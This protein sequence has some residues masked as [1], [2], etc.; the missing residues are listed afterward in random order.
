MADSPVWVQFKIIGMRLPAAA[1]SAA[2]IA[3]V[4]V[5]TSTTATA[6]AASWPAST[7]APRPAS[8]TTAW[9][10]ASATEAA[11]RPPAASAAWPP[12]SATTAFTGRPRFIDHNVA[13]HEIVAVQSLHGAIGFL[14]VIDLNKSEAARLARKTVAHQCNDRRGDSRLSK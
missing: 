2:T 6:T 13:T 14:V 5:P 3:A 7:A 11:T 10:P 1:A 4:A 12:A 8:T 9:P